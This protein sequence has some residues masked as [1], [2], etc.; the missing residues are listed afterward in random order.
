MPR[1]GQ[2][3]KGL[4]LTAFERRANLLSRF[5]TIDVP[6]DGFVDLP[7]QLPVQASGYIVTHPDHGVL[8]HQPPLSF[9]RS[10]KMNMG[11]VGRTVKVAA[12]KTDSPHSANADYVVSEIAHDLPSVVGEANPPIGL[13]R[14]FEAEARRERR[15]QARRYEQTW[16]DHDGRDEALKFIRTRIGRARNYVLVADPYFGARQVMQFLHD[17]PRIDVQLTILTSRLAFDSDSGDDGEK[18]ASEIAT[19]SPPDEIT[20]RPKARTELRRL[21]EFSQSMAT[22]KDRGI[23]NAVA[24]VLPEKTPQ[25]HDRFLVIDDS[26][27]FLGNSLNALGDR[28]SLILQVPDS[29]P[30]LSRL[31]EMRKKAI[32]F[33]EYHERRRVSRR[34]KKEA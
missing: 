6:E 32:T 7:Q 24:F 27:W 4:R 12:P 14:V 19:S 1:P 10:F 9:V 17:V 20:V 8:V 28:A 21:K 23:E 3:V 2:S 15:A 25:L 22:F 18:A 13:A 11:I 26:V 31:E 16:F 5:E 30:I 29:E 34:P 33:D